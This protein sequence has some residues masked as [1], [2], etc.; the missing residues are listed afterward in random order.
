MIRTA[1]RST[2][3]TIAAAAL[4]LTAAGAGAGYA[5]GQITGKD[6]KDKSLGPTDL[7]VRVAAKQG[8]DDAIPSGSTAPRKALQVKIKAPTKGYLVVTASS[9]VFDFAASQ[10]QTSCAIAVD[11]KYAKG[12]Y[13]SIEVGGADTETNCETNVTVPVAA[14]AHTVAFY[15]DVLDAGVTYDETALSAEFIPFNG[16][17]KAPTNTQIHAALGDPAFKASR[18]TGN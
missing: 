17:G 8:D 5:A 16:V 12:S 10:E 2:V 1:S 14:G 11:D 4:V 3:L 18:S 9:D 15:A 7:L 13:R 6:I